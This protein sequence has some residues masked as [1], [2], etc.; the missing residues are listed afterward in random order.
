MYKNDIN[1]PEL[2]VEKK[3][4][5]DV[6][7]PKAEIMEA[8]VSGYAGFKVMYNRAEVTNTM[9]FWPRTFGA[10]QNNRE[11]PGFVAALTALNPQKAEELGRIDAYK[12]TSMYI[13][14]F[15][16]LL[17]LG[18]YYFFGIIGAILLVIAGVI[19]FKI[20]QSTKLDQ[21][22]KIL[23]IIFILGGTIVFDFV[24]QIIFA[25]LMNS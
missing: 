22:I 9:A 24:L 8:L 18:G 15:S 13:F 5:I 14:A 3:D 10:Y 25:L 7:A 23:L 17:G 1:S 16:I 20:Y 12:D 4:I 11:L 19:S 21:T 6:M 2:V